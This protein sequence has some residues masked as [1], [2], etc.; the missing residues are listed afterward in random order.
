MSFS[1]IEERHMTYLKNVISLKEKESRHLDLS[2]FVHL[3]SYFETRNDNHGDLN[4]QLL[5][6]T[7]RYNCLQEFEA[8]TI[9]PHLK[10]IVNNPIAT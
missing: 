1:D 4:G 9:G 10:I 8:P 3:N 6:R 2:T 5:I 7:N